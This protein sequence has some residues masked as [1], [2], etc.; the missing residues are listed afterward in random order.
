MSTYINY[1]STYNTY[2]KIH[3]FGGECDRTQVNNEHGEQN[4]CDFYS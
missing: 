4:W 2:V 1:S 3:H